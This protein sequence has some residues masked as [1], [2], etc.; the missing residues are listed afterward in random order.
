MKQ[1][2][3][4]QQAEGEKQ[5]GQQLQTIIGEQVMHALGQPIGFHL[6][7]VRKLW[8]DRYRV[9]VFV[10]PDAVSATVAHSFFLIT[11]GEGNIVNANPTITKH[12]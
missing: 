7:Q 8:E 6:L 9:N 4:N 12:Y 10:G 3:E 11:D 5:A 2:V 1:R